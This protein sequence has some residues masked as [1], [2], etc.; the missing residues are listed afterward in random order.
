MKISWW[1]L[2]NQ[3]K[4][5]RSFMMAAPFALLILLFPERITFFTLGKVEFAI[6]AAVVMV[7][8]GC[9][10]KFKANSERTIR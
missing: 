1:N 9:Y 8:Q 4:A 7:A 3:E 6:V 10:Y 5:K 2:S